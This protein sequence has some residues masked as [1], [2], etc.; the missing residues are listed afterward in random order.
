ME[1][2]AASPS[3]NGPAPP[4]DRR[5]N[6]T[7]AQSQPQPPG[8]VIGRIDVV[9]VAGEQPANN[10]SGPAVRANSGFFSRNYLKRL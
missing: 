10:P 7:R 2:E 9:V 4:A 5:P 8:L 6:S 1:N 3:V